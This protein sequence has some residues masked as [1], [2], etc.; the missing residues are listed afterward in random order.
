MKE[1][2]LHIH[3]V[4]RYFSMFL[5]FSVMV[6]SYL[7]WKKEKA[8][9]KWHEVVARINIGVNHLQ[10]LLGIILMTHSP[11]VS[12]DSERLNNPKV[13]HWSI[14]HPVFMMLA[15]VMVTMA[16]MVVRNKKD[17]LSKHRLTFVFNL[18]AFTFLSSGI[19]LMYKHH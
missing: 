10:M 9:T 6:W 11:F 8:Y 5:I 18:L 13:F 12:Y 15:V 7:N 2:I 3:S 4:V 14:T 1:S 19:W 17:D 16:L